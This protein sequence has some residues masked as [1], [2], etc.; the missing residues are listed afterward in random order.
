MANTIFYVLADLLSYNI[1]RD[2]EL[3]QSEKERLIKK[4]ENGT[5]SIK[6]I[7]RFGQQPTEPIDEQY[8]PLNI[9][10]DYDYDYYD[11]D[12]RRDEEEQRI[13]EEEQRI[14]DEEYYEREDERAFERAWAE[15]VENRRY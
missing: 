6:D 14:R 7:G 8:L 11:D 4:V 13:R 10:I 5:I 2:K 3:N 12:I 9:Y 1:R 15:H